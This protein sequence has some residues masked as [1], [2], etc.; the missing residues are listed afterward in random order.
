[1]SLSLIGRDRL[2][3]RSLSRRFV[4]KPAH[5]YRLPQGTCLC[6]P[7]LWLAK[8]ERKIYPRPSPQP[9]SLW[10]FIIFPSIIK[11][12]SSQIFVDKSA[13]RSKQREILIKWIERSMVE[14]SELM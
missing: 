5:P 8:T 1:M 12:T 13:M 11:I 6:Q 3:A 9:S 7:M 14:G 4:G 2:L 10:C